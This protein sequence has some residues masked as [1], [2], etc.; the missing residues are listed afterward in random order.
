MAVPGVRPS[1]KEP[2]ELKPKEQLIPKSNDNTAMN[3]CSRLQISS[4]HANT[5]EENWWLVLANNYPMKE[6]VRENV[7]QFAMLIS[8]L[9]P[10]RPL[11]VLTTLYT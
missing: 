10:R 3:V 1:K 8:Y 5:A 7:E 6:L 9:K 11:M 2:K 4:S